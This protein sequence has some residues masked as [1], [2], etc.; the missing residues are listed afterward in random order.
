MK[1]MKLALKLGLGF[2]ALILL[3][4]FLGLVAVWNMKSVQGSATRLND[5]YIAEVDLATKLERATAATILAMRGYRLSDQRDYLEAGRKSLA[6]IQ[7]YLQDANDL[8]IKYP[9]LTKLK[10]AADTTR[11]KVTEYDQFTDQTVAKNEFLDKNRALLNDA[12]HQL[13][14]HIEEYLVDQ[15]KKM[16]KEISA[17]AEGSKLN[18]R[19]HKIQQAHE[20]A[21]LEEDIQIA[22]WKSQASRD[23]KHMKEVMPNF[24][25]IDKL[26]AEI[27]TATVDEANIKHLDAIK[28]A[29]HTYQDCVREV[30][31]ATTAREEIA[32]TSRAVASEMLDLARQTSTEGMNAAKEI[33]RESVSKLS[34]ASIM[35]LGGLVVATVFGFA[36]AVL[37][38]RAITRPLANAVDVCNRMSQG[39]FTV[40]VTVDSTDEV[41]RL[42]EALKNM[43]ANMRR[44]ISDVTSGVQTLASSS[45]ELSAISSQMASNSASMSD[46]SS[47]VAAAAEEM[48]ANMNSVAAASEEAATNVNMV[49]A[50]A[51]EMSVTV[52]E[53]AQ[54]SAKGL[55]ITSGA[56]SRA[57]TVSEKVNELGRAAQEISKVTEVITEISSQTNLL[58][59]NATIEAGKGF[60][61]VA[62]EIK[63]LA[64]QT[65]Q[66]TQ[67]IK[68]RIDGIQGST[69]E[70][71]SQ[72]EQITAVINEVYEIVTTIAAAVEEQ[73]AT[74]QDIAGNVAQA[75]QGI[76]EVNLNINQSSAVAGTISSD[77]AGVNQ[78]VREISTAGGQVNGTAD[79]LSQ[80]AKTLQQLVSRFKV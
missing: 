47:T 26:V 8:A 60:A 19:L 27:R 1:N 58:A 61:V 70:T 55:N 74:S 62:N 31:A 3:L 42:L 73:S 56:V 46:R 38:T 80:L 35:L 33:S 39:D 40:A 45:T 5:L 22:F 57:A 7:K 9:E 59:L 10:A 36:I 25:K 34:L 69:A 21:E 53:I 48:S 23:A 52:K 30:Q 6:E 18:P 20:L 2:G 78:S 67:D 68:A 24:D 11:A 14:Q 51:E 64:R 54:N 71:V 65:A 12:A 44:M 77:I 28:S 4:L 76:Q 32:K 66:A 29:S 63:E 72:I 75:S 79:G 13:L 17:G 50:A 15:N 43:A 49:A 16:S 41:G 37:L